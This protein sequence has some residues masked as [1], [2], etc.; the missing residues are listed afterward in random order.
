MEKFSLE[1]ASSIVGL[2]KKKEKLLSDI[3]KKNR[4]CFCRSKILKTYISVCQLF[5][6]RLMAKIIKFMEDK[7]VEKTLAGSDLRAWYNSE[8]YDKL[9]KGSC[10]NDKMILLMRL[11]QDKTDTDF[12][13]EYQVK[14]E[15]L[16]KEYNGDPKY[17][18]EGFRM[19]FYFINDWMDNHILGILSCKIDCSNIDEKIRKDY[20]EL[21]ENSE[22]VLNLK[23]CSISDEC[24]SCIRFNGDGCT[25]CPS[26]SDYADG[27]DLHIYLTDEILKED[28]ICNFID[29]VYLYHTKPKNVDLIFDYI[30]FDDPMNFDL[31]RMYRM[32]SLVQRFKSLKIINAENVDFG[33]NKEL[34]KPFLN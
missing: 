34:V 15:R 23:S 32:Q 10:V 25:G 16:I 17:F 19:F 11:L 2:E 4:L 8:M 22:C 29:V 5:H 30:M 33:E 26:H 12:F 13:N 31:D 28:H 24:S 3:N 20:K 9:L 21:L 18:I 1:L 6:I 14:F 27:E 7:D